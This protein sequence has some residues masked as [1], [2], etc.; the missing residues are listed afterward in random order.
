MD[1]VARVHRLDP[2]AGQPSND[3]YL[4]KA[5]VLDPISGARQLGRSLEVPVRDALRALLF[6]QAARGAG[7]QQ[8]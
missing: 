3:R 5:V 7:S 8:G 6:D 4:R 1:C 2:F